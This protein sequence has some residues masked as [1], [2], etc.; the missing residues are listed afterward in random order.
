MLG[1]RVSSIAAIVGI[2]IVALLVNAISAATRFNV[3]EARAISTLDK[4]RL[5]HD[6]KTLAGGVVAASLLFLRDRTRATRAVNPLAAVGGAGAGAGAGACAPRVLAPAK[7]ALAHRLARALGLWAAHNRQFTDVRRCRET[8]DAVQRDVEALR[9]SVRDLH[10]K[11]DRALAGGGGGG[12]APPPPP[13][14][15][16]RRADAASPAWRRAR[17]AETGE[18][19]W[20]NAA[21]ETAWELPAGAVSAEM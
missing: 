21:G 18:E 16:R 9:D 13:R 19:W 5:S 4:K 15:V 17:D 3:D 7:S 11:L 10:E 1:R 6:H 12:G 2:I 14:P 8:S 20:V